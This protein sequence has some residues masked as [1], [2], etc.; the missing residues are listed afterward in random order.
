PQTL[1]NWRDKFRSEPAHNA[2]PNGWSNENKAKAV[3]EYARLSQ[4][5][6]GEWLRKSGLKSEHLE[7]WE[8]ELMTMN[9]SRKYKEENKILKKQNKQLEKEILKKD[10]ALAELSAIVILKKKVQD[11]FPSEKED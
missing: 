8:K 1:Y 3:L 9:D 2:R 5:E 7:L 6:I 4:T 10:K 11:I